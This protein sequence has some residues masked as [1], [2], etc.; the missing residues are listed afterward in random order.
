[1]KGLPVGLDSYILSGKWHE[2]MD[3]LSIAVRK[4]CFRLLTIPG[5]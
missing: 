5:E 1:M 4:G 3:G 2:V